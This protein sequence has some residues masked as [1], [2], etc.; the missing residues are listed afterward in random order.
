M[1]IP[2][3]E[4]VSHR[5]AHI[6]SLAKRTLSVNN[7]VFENWKVT[8]CAQCNAVHP[9]RFA[10]FPSKYQKDPWRR[11]SFVHWLTVVVKVDGILSLLPPGQWPFLSSEVLFGQFSMLSEESCV[12]IVGSKGSAQVTSKCS[13]AQPSLGGWWGFGTTGERMGWRSA[14]LVWPLSGPVI[15]VQFHGHRV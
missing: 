8:S 10:E 1:I 13:S 4:Y 15:L 2:G 14:L 9:I 6:C 11:L 5:N 7:G 12:R 3:R